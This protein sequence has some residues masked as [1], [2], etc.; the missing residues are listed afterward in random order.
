MGALLFI[1]MFVDCHHYFMLSVDI[2]VCDWLKA[3]A[4]SSFITKAQLMTTELQNFPLLNVKGGCNLTGL[5]IGELYI[6]AFKSTQIS[7]NKITLKVMCVFWGCLVWAAGKWAHTATFCLLC[8][9]TYEIH[10]SILH[11]TCPL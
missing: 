8:I 9:L 5:I 4:E 1:I 11:R 3:N 7:N 2:C 10:R 6:D